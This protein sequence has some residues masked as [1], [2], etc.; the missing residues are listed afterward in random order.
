VSLDPRPRRT[1]RLAN[2]ELAGL[3]AQLLGAGAAVE[4]EARGGSMSP[5]V[6]DGDVVTIT[7]FGA[8]GTA[9]LRPGAVVA[10]RH[11]QG[12]RLVVHRLLRREGAGWLAR[13]DRSRQPDGVVA[14]GDLLGLVVGVARRGWRVPLPRGR[15]G[16]ALVSAGRLALAARDRLRRS[17]APPRQA[18]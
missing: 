2:Q 9:L 3:V 18:T 12:D 11:P 4:L 5:W 17:P 16:L 10:F 15:A 1:V 8:A 7:P 13:G 6:R 14:G